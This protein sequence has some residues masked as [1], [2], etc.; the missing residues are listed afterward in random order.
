MRRRRS[1]DGIGNEN[2]KGDRITVFEFEG[3]NYLQ[4]AH[5]LVWFREEKPEWSIETEYTVIDVDHAVAKAT[6]KNELG[7]IMAT[8][9]KRE[10][11]KHFLDFLE[12][13]EAGA[14]GRALAY[15]GYGTQFAPEFDEG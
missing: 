14:V 8:A 9:H 5:R 7:R 10:D 4:V 2:A 3:K 15:V 11:Q 1:I 13:A 6:V 12:K